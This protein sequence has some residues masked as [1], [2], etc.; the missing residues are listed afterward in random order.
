VK[1]KLFNATIAAM[2]ITTITMIA[3]TITITGWMH[4]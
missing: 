1:L 2:C 3:I 4:L